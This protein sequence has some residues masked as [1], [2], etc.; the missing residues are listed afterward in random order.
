MFLLVKKDGLIIQE[1]EK[2]KKKSRTLPSIQKSFNSHFPSS[3]THT[4]VFFVMLNNK[5]M[6]FLLL[7]LDEL[8]LNIFS[9]FNDVVG[10]SELAC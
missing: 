3:V 6:S 8:Y 7:T 10:V 2:Q 1:E 9:L 5:D 4:I